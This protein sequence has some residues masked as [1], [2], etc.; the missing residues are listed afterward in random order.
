L[1]TRQETPVTAAVVGMVVAVCAAVACAVSAAVVWRE[2][3]GGWHSLR[4]RRPGYTA[5]AL[6]VVLGLP[7]VPLVAFQFPSMPQAVQVALLYSLPW[8]VG[9]AVAGWLGR[10]G[11]IAALSTVGL[12]MVLV[13]AEYAVRT[14]TRTW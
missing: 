13:V 11:R 6:V 14:L 8:G 10:P 1:V 4:P 12:S 7:V 3:A 2:P 5:A 9:I